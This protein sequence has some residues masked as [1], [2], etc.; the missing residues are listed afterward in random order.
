MAQC[1][2]DTGGIEPPQPSAQQRRG[3][4]RLREHA[5]ARSDEGLLAEAL[6]PGANRGWRKRLDRGTQARR[7]VAVAGEEALHVLA[8]GEIEAAAPGQQELAPD[9]WPSVIHRDARAMVRQHLGRHQ[10]GRARADNG[11]VL[12]AHA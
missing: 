5:A 4:E 12:A 1:E 2:A 9:R 3:L 11:D 6:T 8:V 7:G 10:P